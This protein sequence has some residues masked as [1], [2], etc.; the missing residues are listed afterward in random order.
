MN[1][2]FYLGLALSLLV[3]PVGFAIGFNI[4]AKEEIKKFNEQKNHL[5][6]GV[7]K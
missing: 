6:F 3:F 4:A 2:Q 5:L 1:P 7:L